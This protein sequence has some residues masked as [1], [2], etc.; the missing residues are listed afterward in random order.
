MIPPVYETLTASADVT[1]IVNDRIRGSGFVT[2]GV[3]QP[4]IAWQVVSTSPANTL[5]CRPDS[6]SMRVQIDC[7]ATDEATARA[8]ATAV[9]DAM[10]EPA[11]M[12]SAWNTHEHGTDTN[13]TTDLFRW[14]MDFDWIL[15]R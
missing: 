15:S 2:A 11:Y 10:E 8:L 9:R 3:D 6:D 12:L 4:Y 5:A 1:A 13:P 14:S 7:Y